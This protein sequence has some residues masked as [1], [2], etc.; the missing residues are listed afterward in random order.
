MVIVKLAR[1]N[2]FQRSHL[3]GRLVNPVSIQ[4]KRAAVTASWTADGTDEMHAWER[5]LRG[6]EGDVVGAPPRVWWG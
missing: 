1:Q 4:P 3:P 5:G 2:I 6:G